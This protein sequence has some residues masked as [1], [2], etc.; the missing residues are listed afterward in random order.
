VALANGRSRLV[1]TDEEQSMLRGD[2]T[3]AQAVAMRVVCKMAEI[4]GA[5]RLVPVR[6][7]HIDS[8]L[9]HGPAGLLFAERL[10]AG[11]GRVGV[12]ATLNVSALDLLHPELVR[13]DDDTRAQARRLM[14]VYVEMG[15]APTWT[16]A[17][18][19]LPSRPRL[20]EHI[21][22][23]ESNAI[24]FA[25]SVL[26]ARTGR[27]GD[28][29]DICAAITGRVPLR[30]LHTDDG[31]RARVAFVI[32]EA[33]TERF[34]RRRP[35]DELF[36]LVG[37]VVGRHAA[38]LVPALVGLPP[39]T[40]EDELKALGAAAASSGA[41]GLCHVVGVTPEARSLE[42]ATGGREPDQT[43][44][45]TAEMLRQAWDELTNVPRD[46]AGLRAVSVGTPH[47]SLAEFEALDGLL[48][49][50]RVHPDITFY[51]STGRGIL[52]QLEN[53]GLG[54]RLRRAGATIVTDTCTYITP[55]LDGVGGTVMTNSAKWAWYAPGNIGVGV[56]Y[57]SLA[58]CVESAVRGK[59]RNERPEYLVG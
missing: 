41:V 50:R 40:T 6:S 29:I 32:E 49:G 8:C 56:V 16:C 27:Y 18:Y 28:F 37:H 45:V 30:G 44:S 38:S 53:A 54:E 36:G 34:A 24:V 2:G 42:H 55:I 31:R 5:E 57:G 21:A 1:L 11:G 15:C 3:P 9:Y 52:E 35:T 14:D 51:V 59:V 23:A 48:A 58:D 7:A 22:W 10:L 46:G 43:I 33:L 19:Q 26:G 17:P 13:L 4:G 20:G 47:F 39:D 12:Q 25:N